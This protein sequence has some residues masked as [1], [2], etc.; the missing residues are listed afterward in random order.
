M[1]F[2]IFVPPLGTRLLLSEM[3]GF[4]L[5]NE[6][7]NATLMALMGDTRELKYHDPEPIPAT[8]QAGTVLIIDRYYIRQGL[9]G[10]DSVSFRME[11]ANASA[12]LY[13]GLGSQAKRQVR[14]WA[15]LDDVNKMRVELAPEPVKAARSKKR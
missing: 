2:T 14:F 3:W 12:P 5:Y 13:H 6:R 10:F 1:S 15:K 11:G 8:L 4:E 9:D 7:R